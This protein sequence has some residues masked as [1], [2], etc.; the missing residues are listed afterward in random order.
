MIE[1]H[2]VEAVRRAEAAA[3]GVLPDGALM[4][5]ASS[6][7]ASALLRLLRDRTGGAYGRRVVL[8]VGPGSNGGDALWAGARLA[9]RGVAVRAVLTHEKPHP[10][11]RAGLLGAGGRV[12]DATAAGGEPVAVEAISGAD[13]VVDGLLGIGGRGGLR[14]VAASLIEAVD[15]HGPAVVAVDL[16]S[17]VDPDT[18]AADGIHVHA[19]LTVTFGTAKPCLL[20][21]PACAAAGRV[22]VVD[23]GLEAGE[24]GSPAVRRF[25]V[26]DAGARWPVPGPADDKYSRGVLGVVAGGATYSGAAVLCTGAAV[27]SGAGMVRYVGP[28]PATDLVR[29]SWP[30]VV[31]GAGRVQAWVLGPGVDGDD[32]GQVEA[33]RSALAGQEPCLLDA[34]ALQVLA[35]ALRIGEAVTPPLLLTPHAG[36]LARLLS[37]LGVGSPSRDEVEAQ[38]LRH[39]RAAVGATGATVLLKG[40]TTVV[41]SP[42]GR[43]LAQDHGP[44]WLATAGSGDVLAG[45]AGTLLA[46]GLE[47]VDA[48]GVAVV[49]HGLAGARA[50]GG[51]PFSAGALI[52]HLPAAVAHVLNGSQ[53]S[54]RN[55][56]SSQA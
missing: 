45:V 20:L 36:E 14:G 44:H 30:E 2:G 9:R 10:G 52:D 22:E 15:R 6:A 26:A 53:L 46:A 24:L 21:P 48:A 7:L 37:D 8:L 47:P 55:R 50:S 29:A 32:T 11:G 23:I 35:L 17:G 56:A 40:A 4:Q 41:V 42:D 49:V 27:R 16:P 5:R 39:A 43:V 3:M 54:D 31:P 38:P 19:G 51:G 18:G 28:E 34:G 25:E 13:V 12:I 33:V 1:A